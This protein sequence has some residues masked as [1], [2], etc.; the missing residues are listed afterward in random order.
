MLISS[1]P[2]ALLIA[3]S[4]KA[5][6]KTR[7]TYRFRYEAVK[8]SAGWPSKERVGDVALQPRLYCVEA[9]VHA[10][11]E[12]VEIHVSRRHQGAQPLRN[13]Q[14]WNGWGDWSYKGERLADLRDRLPA[15]EDAS[16]GQGSA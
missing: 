1:A 7:E 13:T 11:G 8:R 16:E 14:S 10:P 6:S 2:P 4:S 3:S 15:N 5:L 12:G 9:L